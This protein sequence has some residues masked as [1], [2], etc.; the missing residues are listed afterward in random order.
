MKK[1]L[2][3]DGLN[4]YIFIYHKINVFLRINPPCKECLI[5]NMCLEDISDLLDEFVGLQI[6]SCNLL[7]EFIIKEQK[8]F[9]HI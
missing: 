7:R 8:K 4:N 9:N 3:A 1:I 5:Q 6:R 2:Y